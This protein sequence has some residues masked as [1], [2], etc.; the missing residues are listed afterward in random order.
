MALSP[1]EQAALDALLAKQNEPETPTKIFTDIYDV[2]SF[3]VHHSTAFSG[4]EDLRKEAQDTINEASGRNQ[5]ESEDS[6]GGE[7]S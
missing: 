7:A 2:V 5:D 1:Q 3:L 6:N 4:N